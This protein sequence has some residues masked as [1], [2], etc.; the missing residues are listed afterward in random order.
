MTSLSHDYIVRLSFSFGATRD[1]FG[2]TDGKPR[3]VRSIRRAWWWAVAD[4]TT[5]GLRGM[6]YP[7]TARASSSPFTSG[8]SSVSR[9]SPLPAAILGICVQAGA[10]GGLGIMSAFE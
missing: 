3:R 8:N 6:F 1:V 9:P 5:V 10:Q 4:L 7:I 2:R